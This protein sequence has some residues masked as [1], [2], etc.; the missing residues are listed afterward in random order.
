M[1]MDRLQ[2]DA[3]IANYLRYAHNDQTLDL[4]DAET[5]EQYGGD[6]S[7]EII[8]RDGGQYLYRSVDTHITVYTII[9]TLNPELS[10]AFEA[11]A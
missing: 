9:D 7:N 1:F 10:K 2:Q 8:A 11:F 4:S 5:I 3:I 6:T